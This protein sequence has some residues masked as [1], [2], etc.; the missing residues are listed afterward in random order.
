MK[1]G[2]ESDCRFKNEFISNNVTREKRIGY[3]QNG[4]NL[5]CLMCEALDERQ[6]STKQK[7]YLTFEWEGELYQFCS[8]YNHFHWKLHKPLLSIL[9][10]ALHALSVFVDGAWISDKT[11]KK[12]NDKL[13][14]QRL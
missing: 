3:T 4:S 10:S 14:P 9:K 12:I 5:N 1:G 2:I 7:N 8:I 11:P 6:R 13:P